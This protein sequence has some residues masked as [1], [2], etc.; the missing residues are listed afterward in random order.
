[1]YKAETVLTAMLIILTF[2][3]V[4]LMR[5][6]VRLSDKLERLSLL[7]AFILNRVIEREAFNGVGAEK[8]VDNKKVSGFDIIHHFVD[9]KHRLHRDNGNGSANAHTRNN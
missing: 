3:L 5:Q 7:L 9:L 6:L 8:E 1:M 2:L 4:I